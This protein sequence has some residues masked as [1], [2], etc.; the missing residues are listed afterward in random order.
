MS[1]DEYN[2]LSTALSALEDLVENA[3]EELDARLRALEAIQNA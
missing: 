2:A 3:I 1:S